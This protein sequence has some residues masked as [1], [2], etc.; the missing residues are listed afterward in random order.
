MSMAAIRPP[1]RLCQPGPFEQTFPHSME[2]Q[3][4]IWLRMGQ[5]FLRCSKSVDDRQTDDGAC[6]YYKLTHEPKGS[7]ELKTCL[8]KSVA[9]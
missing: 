4:E 6:L 9:S 8:M 5:L 7:G 3:Y 1:I 2:A